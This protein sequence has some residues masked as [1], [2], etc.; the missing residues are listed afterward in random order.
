MNCINCKSDDMVQCPSD[1]TCRNCGVEQKIG[2]I[3]EEVNFF[4]RV[5]E[6][7]SK[8]ETIIGGSKYS[9]LNKTA[10]KINNHQSTME[11]NAFSN[12]HEFL[13]ISCTQTITTCQSMLEEYS[14][15]KIIKTYKRRLA[16][17]LAIIS[18]CTN[19][20]D[21]VIKEIFK[22]NISKFIDDVVDVL[23]HRGEMIEYK[24]NQELIWKQLADI[25][26]FISE[27][28]L[29]RFRRNVFEVYD[30]IKSNTNI[31]SCHE[32]GKN[33]AC[34]Y[35]AKDTLK[36]SLKLKDIAMVCDA[37]CVNILYIVRKIRDAKILL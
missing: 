34:M 20:S 25:S 8:L 6:P 18:L 5:G 21:Q 35:I 11:I 7:N 3:I 22:I 1:V 37:T 33:G 36:I 12:V 24:N 14:K 32:K 16:T 26:S 13:N 23:K 28:N 29:H 4:E 2:N 9:F 31:Q 27:E 19:K 15:I 10:K 17:Y 30:K